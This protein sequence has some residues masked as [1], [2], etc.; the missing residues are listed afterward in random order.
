MDGSII[1]Q[2]LDYFTLDEG[3]D[4]R[5]GVGQDNAEDFLIKG[6]SSQIEFNQFPQ[7]NLQTFVVTP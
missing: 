6:K 5:G 2:P 3:D 7:G 4:A 1:Q